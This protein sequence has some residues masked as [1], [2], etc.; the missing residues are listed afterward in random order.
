[1][2]R[3]IATAI[4]EVTMNHSRVRVA[5]RAALWTLRRLVIEIVIAKKT[6][7]A[8]A[9]FSSW[10]KISPILVRVVPS[11]ATSQLRAAQPRTT[12]RTR[13]AR[14][15]TQNG[16]LGIR[17]PLL[18]PVPPDVA[19]ADA[20]DVDG[21]D[22]EDDEDDEDTDRLR[23]RVEESGLGEEA[24]RAGIAGGCGRRAGG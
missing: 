14:I 12:P 13:P 16:I 22:D 23:R 9:S 15:C 11:Q 3:P 18:G 1:M 20:D 24:S 2:T 4:S 21:E 6:S 19:T 8:T 7:G 17:K 5:S 10:T